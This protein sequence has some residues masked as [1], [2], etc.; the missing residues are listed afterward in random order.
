M[1]NEGKDHLLK[2]SIKKNKTVHWHEFV[3]NYAG[4]DRDEDAVFSTAVVLNSLI[5]T[6]TVRNGRK[7]T[8]DEDTP[9]EVKETIQKGVAYV[10]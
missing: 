2:R 9:D 4:K 3:G 1:K 10:L 7:I 6:W 8:Y 5:D